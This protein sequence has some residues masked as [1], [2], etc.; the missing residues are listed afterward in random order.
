M[1]AVIKAGGKQYI[2][3]P[4]Q[5]IEIDVVAEGSKKL[6]FEPLMI[7]DGEKISVGTPVVKNMTVKAEVLGDT[8]GK[9]I[10]VLKFKAKKRIKKQTGH[11]QKYTKIKITGIAASK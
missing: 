1:Q 2:V 6:D 9:K 5:T 11:R 3:A 4:D 10:K 7:I 8:K